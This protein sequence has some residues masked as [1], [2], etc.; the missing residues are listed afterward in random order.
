MKIFTIILVCS[1][2]NLSIN[3]C[4]EYHII[5]LLLYIWLLAILSY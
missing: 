3:E 1:I 5:Y 4:D 2:A